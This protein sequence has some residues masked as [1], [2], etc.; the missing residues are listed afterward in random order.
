MSY[1]THGQVRGGCGHRHRTIEA[2]EACLSRD[3]RACNSA[4]GYSDRV[5]AEIDNDGYLINDATGDYVYPDHGRST[6]AVKFDD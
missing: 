3:I 6:G 4:G 5:V 2:A 1:T